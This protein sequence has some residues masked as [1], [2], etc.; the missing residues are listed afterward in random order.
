MLRGKEE[1]LEELDQYFEE[2][3]HQ[4]DCLEKENE[5]IRERIVTKELYLQKLKLEEYRNTIIN[6]G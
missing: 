5:Q 3:E 1:I 2:L 6:I 4:V